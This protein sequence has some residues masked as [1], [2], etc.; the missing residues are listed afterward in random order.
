MMVSKAWNRYRLRSFAAS[1]ALFAWCLVA[2][3][4]LA[5]LVWHS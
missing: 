3:C 5:W 2:A 4:A 1:A